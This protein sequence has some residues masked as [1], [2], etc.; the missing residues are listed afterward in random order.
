MS[1]YDRF[2]RSIPGLMDELAPAGTPD[3]FDDLLRATATERQRP[4][5]SFPERWLP[6]DIAARPLVTRSVPWRPLAILA[7]MVLAA[8][9]TV[10]AYVGSQPKLPA[11]FGP[12]GNGVLFFRSSDGSVQSLH[13]STGVLATV[14]PA[15]D[16]LG[17][18]VP[19]RDGQRLAFIPQSPASAP[20][21]VAGIDGSNRITLAGEYRNIATVQWSPDGG[22]IAVL[23]EDRGMSSIAVAATDGSG[24][25]T[26]ALQRSVWQLRYLADG[27]LAIIAAEQ[28]GGLCPAEDITAGPCAL[29]LVNADGTG[30]TLLRSA[31]DF[32]GLGLDASPDGTQLVYVEWVAPNATGRLHVIDVADGTD[33]PIP[34]DGFPPEYAINRAFFSPD[35]ASILFDLFEADAAHWAVVPSSGGAPV[36][37]GLERQGDLG[38]AAWAPDGQSILARYA[39]SDTTSE[40]WLLDRSGRGEDRRLDVEAPYLPEWQRVVATR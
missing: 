38:D 16:G 20:I 27:R 28:P 17:D 29:F 1:T 6:V 10:V 32:N 23:A 34:S 21:V 35:G 11:P 25:E 39:T 24:A 26:L 4:A 40:L 36:K 14:A 12:T 8:V 3:Y 33:R 5:W 30:L 7:L 9:A 31:S 15:S 19:S 22:H 18:P 2:E 13:P 37:I